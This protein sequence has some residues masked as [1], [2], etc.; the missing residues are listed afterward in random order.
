LS[1]IDYIVF[2]ADYCAVLALPVTSETSRLMSVTFRSFAIVLIILL[3]ILCCFAVFF[4]TVANFDP[5]G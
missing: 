3:F 2:C 1:I 4:E 5:V